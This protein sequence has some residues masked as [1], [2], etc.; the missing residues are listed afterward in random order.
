M[1]RVLV[2]NTPQDAVSTLRRAREAA[3]LSQSEL[4]RRAGVHRAT[5][6]RRERYPTPTGALRHLILALREVEFINGGDP[7][8]SEL[9][10]R[11]TA[12]ER[13]LTLLVC[14]RGGF[15]DDHPEGEA[16]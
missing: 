7:V 13:R 15:G 4:A 6:A 1:N 10:A 2:A 3:R 16:A 5:V 9:E 8:L 12:V 11:L 14:A